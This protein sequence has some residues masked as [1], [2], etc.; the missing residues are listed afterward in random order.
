MSLL[1]DRSWKVL[2]DSDETSLIQEFYEP[3]LSTAL[4]YDRTTGYFSAGVLTLVARGIEGLVR[5]GGKMRLLVGCILHQEDLAAIEKGYSLRETVEAKLLANP[6]APST[7][8]QVDALELLSWMVARGHLDV[9]VAVPCGDDRKP[10]GGLGV[11]HS[12]SGIVEDRAGNRLAFSGSINETPS[13][14]MLQ[15]TSGAGG[16]NWEDFHVFLDWAGSRDHVSAQEE[17]FARLWTDRSPH[18]LVVEMSSAIKNDLLRFLPLDDAVPRRLQ[19]SQSPQ[20]NSGPTPARP[21]PP[22]PADLL[23]VPSPVASP[24]AS[25]EE[26]RRLVW[27]IIR[28]APSLPNGG[29]RVG[30]AT[31]AV[32]PWPYQVRTFHRLY[33]NWPPKLLIADEVGLGKTIEA[34]LL[35]RQAW[36]SGRAKRILILAPKSVLSQWQIE[37]R[38]KFNLNWPIYDGQKLNWYPTRALGDNAVKQVAPDQ[39]H[40]EPCVL[41]SSQLMRRRDRARVL[42]ES[43]E[44]YDLVVL[45]EAHHARR[46]GAGGTGDYRPNQLLRLMQGL[47]ARTRGLILL[48]ATPMQ[49]HPVEVWDLLRLLGLPDEWTEEQF[50]RFFE[51]S[52]HPNPSHQSFESMASLF[53]SVEANLGETPLA[54]AQRLFPGGGNLATRKVL[55]ALRDRAQTQRR[56][57]DVEPRRAAVKIMRAN[58]P[59]SRLVSRH[60]R[61]LLR[62]YIASGKL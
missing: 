24:V 11:F 20:D 36:L 17:S 54:E 32:K 48:T 1:T 56:Q 8:T 39:W 40:R 34:G 45:D 58:S 42:L 44:P 61:G 47:K 53:R 10:I 2:Y 57:L 22:A 23:P 21:V 62:S 49:V 46:R 51:D 43:A 12:K 7:P 3:V 25:P 14:W 29:E 16:G 59:V 4:R 31:S 13:G 55:D 15:D 6:L 19:E 5:N 28:H 52:A 18:C 33:D 60:T 50:I 27:G 35:L 37:L 41:T 26:L 9:K 38:E 30:E